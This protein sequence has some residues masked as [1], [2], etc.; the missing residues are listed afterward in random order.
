MMNLR[1]TVSVIILAGLIFFNAGNAGAEEKEEPK[2]ISIKHGMY[3]KSVNK[4]FGDPLLVQ[5]I[6]DKF[7]PIPK[8]RA[9]YEIGESDYMILY[10]FSGRINKITI[11]S[12]MDREQAV[13]M[14]S[15]MAPGV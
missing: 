2:K 1:R 9:L 11:L 7:W 10:F 14:F 15:T 6:K 5:E 13:E 4:R 8:K 3:E 12:D